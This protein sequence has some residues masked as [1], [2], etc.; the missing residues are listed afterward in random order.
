MA[1]H[2]NNIRH[3][4]LS[5]FCARLA[6]RNGA[7]SADLALGVLCWHEERIAGTQMSTWELT[8]ILRSYGLGNPN[9]ATLASKLSKSPLTMTVDGKF[10]L[11]AGAAQTIHQLFPNAFDPPPPELNLENG[12]LAS[13]VW[14]DTRGYLEK[15]CTQLNGCYQLTFY[16]A[17]SVMVRRSIETLIIEAYEHLH[18]EAEIRDTDGNYFMLGELVSRSISSSGLALGR[19]AKVALKD[20][21]KLGDRSA[22]NRRYNAVKAD[23]DEIRSGVRVVVDELINIASLRRRG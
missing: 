3:A 11:R 5:E 20:I 21:K 19:E 4:G 23:L 14:T 12:Y 1:E 8:R 22:H 18:R 9:R 17:A 13:A 10:R 16:D 7:D 15:V 2:D 6:R